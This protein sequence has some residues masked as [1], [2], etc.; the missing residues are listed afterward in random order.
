MHTQPGDAPDLGRRSATSSAPGALR[1]LSESLDD[2]LIWSLVDAA[3]DGIVMTDEAGQILLVNRQ[4]EEMFGYDRGELLGRSVEEFLPE[5]LR[6]VH[7]AHRTRY[8]VDPRP[9]SMGVGLRLFGRRSDGSEF[10]VEI[11]LSP[12]RTAQGMRIVAAVRDVT[13]RVVAEAQSREIRETLDATRDAVAIFD[14]QTLTFTY[15]NQGFVDQ[16]GYDTDELLTM[17]MLHVAPDFTESRLRELLGPFERGEVTSTTFRT[18]HRRRD[19]RDVPV[20]TLMQ[21]IRGDDGQPRSYV[22]IAR[23]ISARLASEARQQRAEQELR[24]LEDRERMAR[25]LHDL[26]IQRLFAT[27]MSAQ[28]LQARIGDIELAARAANIVDELDLTI[29]EIRTVIFGLHNPTDRDPAGLRGRIAAVLDEQR[30]ALGFAPDLEVVGDIDDISQD[31][32]HHVVAIVREALANVA[33][34]AHATMVE[35]R[36]EARD[37]DLVLRV[38]DNGIGINPATRGGGNGLTNMAQRARSLDAELDVLPAPG[39]GTVVSGR[40]PRSSNR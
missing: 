28:F 31:A 11:S 36:V 7:T 1:P 40:I 18:V 16:I 37:D 9:R 24:V 33:K 27:G 29:R 17:S 15:V 25:D 10:P 13:D 34:H 5:R 21:V 3:P 12:V 20:E 4:T 19:G 8:R 26:V 35:V 22:Q 23:D 32:A 2:E 38:V 6:A 39:G 14:A 30:E